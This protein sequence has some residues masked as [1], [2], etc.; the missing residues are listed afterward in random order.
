ML[1]AIPCWLH[2][3][4]DK[5]CSYTTLPAL[6]G[7]WGKPSLGPGDLGV[8]EVTAC[9]V[10][11]L[12]L[13]TA[14]YARKQSYF[15]PFFFPRRRGWENKDIKGV[16]HPSTCRPILKVWLDKILHPKHAGS[17][18]R[19]GGKSTCNSA[20]SFLS[21]QIGWN[22]LP[23]AWKPKSISTRHTLG[24]HGLYLVLRPGLPLHREIQF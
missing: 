5:T 6:L 17:H 7:P 13:S 23:C 8:Q 11:P 14:S 10:R 12:E 22:K 4:K 15:P 20:L 18:M 21:G 2:R 1:L 9:S 3:Q 16:V 24:L 19:K